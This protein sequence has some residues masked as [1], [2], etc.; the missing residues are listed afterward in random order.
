MFNNFFYIK[1]I[2]N[3]YDIIMSKIKKLETNIHIRELLQINK[4][5]SD[6]NAYVYSLITNTFLDVKNNNLVFNIKFENLE[7]MDEFVTDVIERL[8]IINSPNNS[9][10]RSYKVNNDFLS[11]Y[12]GN[13]LLSHNNKPISPN[14]YNNKNV[15]VD[16]IKTSESYTINFYRSDES[17]ARTIITQL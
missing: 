3:Y 4:Y 14:E 16:I 12:N 17:S 10:L 11:E 9:F 7:D 15:I 8:S 6:N 2:I 1:I 13:K 5:L